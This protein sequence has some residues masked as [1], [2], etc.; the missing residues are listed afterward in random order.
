MEIF[1]RTTILSIF[2]NP[3]WLIPSQ[4]G[5]VI[6]GLYQDNG[7]NVSHSSNACPTRRSS[8]ESSTREHQAA[9]CRRHLT[10]LSTCR[11]DTGCRRQRLQNLLK[12]NSILSSYFIVPTPPFG[13]TKQLCP[14]CPRHEGARPQLPTQGGGRSE[15]CA[16]GDD[17]SPPLF[18]KPIPT[19]SFLYQDCDLVL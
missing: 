14:L 17:G 11:P 9:T 15:C 1:L 6:R 19:I 7:F 18:L 13:L 4:L 10:L 8:A 5:S 12:S 16:E 3:P 2:I